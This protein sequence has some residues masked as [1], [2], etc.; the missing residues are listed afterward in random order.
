MNTQAKNA[1]SL[2]RTDYCGALRAADEGREVVLCGWVQK[3]RDMGQLVF[4][5]L[6]D[7]EGLAQVVFSTDRADLL[8][9]VKKLR[10]EFVAAVRGIVRKRDPKSVNAQMATGEIEIVASAVE[11]VAASKVPPFVVTDPV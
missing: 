6:R 10:P 2:K 11:I 9:T 1:A 5:D 7:R 8:E 4:V 3:A